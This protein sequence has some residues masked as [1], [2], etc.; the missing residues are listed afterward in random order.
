MQKIS[1][2]E[3]CENKDCDEKCADRHPKPCRNKE[4]C[5]FFKNN[6][7]TFSHNASEKVNDK[8][9]EQAKVSNDKFEEFKDLVSQNKLE[10]ESK[11]NTFTN[12]LNIERKKTEEN[13]KVH[14]ELRKKNDD[15]ERIFKK[16]MKELNLKMGKL[17]NSKKD[18]ESKLDET[19]NELKSSQEK[20]ASWQKIIKEMLAKEKVHEAKVKD[21]ENM[22]K[23]ELGKVKEDICRL[24]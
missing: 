3:V 24:N 20:N 13:I 6:N 16:E 14:K 4:K 12:S 17:E 15:L 22:S 18:L 21:L 19:K 9:E 1:R 11:V 7:C 5:K 23:N 10:F 8:V 2:K